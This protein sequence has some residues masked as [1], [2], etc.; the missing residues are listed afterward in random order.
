MTRER[1]HIIALSP[2]DDYEGE[3]LQC[4]IPNETWAANS[5]TAVTP[6]TYRC[7]HTRDVAEPEVWP[8][9]RHYMG[10]ALVSLEAAVQILRVRAELDS[11]IMVDERFQDLIFA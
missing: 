8:S 4:I 7:V 2:A 3:K 6:G 5:E 9:F 1:G 10:E 11:K